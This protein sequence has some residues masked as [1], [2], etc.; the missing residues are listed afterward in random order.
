MTLEQLN[1]ENDTTAR[2]TSILFRQNKEEIEQRGA[3]MRPK[4][5]I[6]GACRN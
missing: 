6:K 5:R 2:R 1:S 4:H 3:E